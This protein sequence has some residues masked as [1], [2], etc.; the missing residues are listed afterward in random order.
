MTNETIK[1]NFQTNFYNFVKK[2]L[3][4]LIIIL[5]TI[6][7]F[8]LIFIFIQNVKKKNEIR[9]SDEY[10]QA[11]ILISQKKITESKLLLESIINKKHNFYSPLALYLI[12]ENNIEPEPLN[13]INFFD[14]ILKNNSIDKENLNLIKIKKAIYLLDQNNEKLI[15][16]TLNPVINSESTW[17]NMAINIIVEYF[18]SKDQ[19]SK[20]N[21]YTELLKNKINK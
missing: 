7:I 8:L 2:N 4:L 1:N 18:L 16:E 3:K 12:I 6:F 21:E 5:V 20:A 10:I 14:I 13:I 17:R 19:N 9:L 11:T 15:I